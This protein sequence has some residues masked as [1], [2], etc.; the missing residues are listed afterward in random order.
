MHVLSSTLLAA[1]RSS[2]GV[3]HVQVTLADRWAGV[4]RLA[5][6]RLYTGSEAD[7]RHAGVISGQAEALLRARLE[8][9]DNTLRYQRVVSPGPSSDFSA[10]EELVSSISSVSGMAL[11]SQGSNTLLSYVSGNQRNVMFRESTDDGV[12]FGAGALIWDPGGITWW[13]AADYSSG[14]TPGLFFVAN[15]TVYWTKKTGSSWSTP[16]AWPHS[17]SSFTGLA[18]RYMEGDWCLVVTAEDAGGASRVWTCIFGDGGAQTAET[19]SSLREVIG[20]DA[21][22]DV[23]YRTPGVERPDLP[24][25]T[26]IEKYVGSGA[27][28]RLLWT[29]SRPD[30]GFVDNQWREPAPF[31]LSLEYGPAM[32]VSADYAWLTTPSG[33]WRGPLVPATVDVSA[34]V[35]EAEVRE[36]GSGGRL[37]LVLENGSGAYNPGVSE[38]IRLGAE[39]GLAWGYQTTQG[40]E[41]APQQRYWVH[42]FERRVEVGRSVAVLEAVDGWGLLEMTRVRRQRTWAS[43]STSVLQMIKDILTMAGIAVMTVSAS[44]PIQMLKPAFTLS[45]N[46]GL[47]DAVRRLL[48]LAPDALRFADGIGEVVYLQESDT[49]AYAYG[50][51]HQVLAAVDAPQLAAVNR[52]QVY[53]TDVIGEALL[54]TDIEAVSDRL[55]QVIDPSLTTSTETSDRAE[56]E[57]RRRAVLPKA[58]EVKVPVNCGQQLYDVVDVTEPSLGWSG[59]LFRVVGLRTWY[60]RADNRAMYKQE[61]DLGGV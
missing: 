3:P 42:S 4:G 44:S 7:S 8:P 45:P 48:T 55:Q 17:L 60:E 57:L 24:R 56:A 39:I 43:G 32:S 41:I 37:R 21:G 31:D 22:S 9:L 27:Y 5:W 53:G 10:W 25:A 15:D 6:E 12:S 50:A 16:Q 38:A 35:L 40:Q 14:G 54:W 26:F 59:K 19:W 47:A 30:A 13:M 29:H 58:G 49:S 2:S 11:A 20:A 46:E 23:T 52:V 18:C 1:Q 61:L 36:T 51:S 28:K 34:D 33:V